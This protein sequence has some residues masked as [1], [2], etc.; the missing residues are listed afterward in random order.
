VLF[1]FVPYFLDQD[2][3]DDTRRRRGLALQILGTI[4]QKCNHIQ[5]DELQASQ[6]EYQRIAFHTVLQTILGLEIATRNASGAELVGNKDQPGD[7]SDGSSDD[8][9]C[10]GEPC[11]EVLLPAGS[12]IL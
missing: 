9:P 8:E 5:S 4:F 2:R 6:A 10:A 12:T 7:N 3:N 11:S 1:D